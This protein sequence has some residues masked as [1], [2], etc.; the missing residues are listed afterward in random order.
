MSWELL[1]P[2]LLLFIMAKSCLCSKLLME[3]QVSGRVVVL[4]GSTSDLAHCEKIGKACGAYGIQSILRVTSAHKGPEE[5][6]RIKA[7]Y[8]GGLHLIFCNV[9]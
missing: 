3:P 6:L 7:E 8:E 1:S 9:T 4:M 5:T 2:V